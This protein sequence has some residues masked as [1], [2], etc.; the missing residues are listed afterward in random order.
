MTQHERVIE[1][2]KTNGSIT[3]I[4]ATVQLGIIDLARTVSAMRKKGI[5]IHGEW[6]CSKNRYGEKVKYMRYSFGESNGC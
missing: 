2:I 3:P 5:E 1:Y 4:E 6:E